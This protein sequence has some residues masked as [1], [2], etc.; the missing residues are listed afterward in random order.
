M[1]EIHSVS[2]L[3][4]SEFL[5][6]TK[7]NEAQLLH[8]FEPDGGIFIAESPKVI[9]RA[10]DF[11]CR[12]I[13][14]LMD[15]SH[16]SQ[17]EEAAILSK[18]S[19][20]DET[21]PIYTAAEDILM[22]ITGFQLTRGMLCAMHRPALPDPWDMIKDASRIAVLENVV[23][24]TNI[25]AI[26]RSAAALGIDAVLLAPGCCDPLTRRAI[27]VSMGNVFLLPW[28]WIT[29]PKNKEGLWPAPLLQKLRE[30]G[31]AS[32]AMALKDDSLH[33]DDAKLKGEKKLAILLGNEGNGLSDE[34]IASCDYSVIIPM[35]HA[36]D[37]LNVAAAS[38]V[39]FWELTR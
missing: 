27:R 16:V 6:Y 17:H 34:T 14:V 23:N 38:A 37:S 3:D 35:S 32:A 10:L 13:S 19:D 28:T 30:E 36:V 15:G 11:G 12:P 39:A 4:K 18:M 29:D 22:G 24:P 8:F 9:E 2:D 7:L 21:I 26:F 31:F 20:L 1:I 5:P 25:G 33:L